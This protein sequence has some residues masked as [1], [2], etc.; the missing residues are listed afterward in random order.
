MLVLTVRYVHVEKTLRKV[1]L[2]CV[3]IFRMRCWRRMEKN[4]WTGSL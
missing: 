3:E 4:S 1:N 2:K